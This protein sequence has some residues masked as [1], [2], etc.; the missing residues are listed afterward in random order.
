MSRLQDHILRDTRVNQPAASAVAVGSIYYV[1]DELVTERSNGSTWDDITDGGAGGGLIPS[2]V[3]ITPDTVANLPAAA[4]AGRV[5]LP[6][7]GYYLYRDN[8][9]SWDTWYNG[10][11]VTEPVDGD[12]AWINQGGASVSITNGG[13]YLSSP[14]SASTN[15]RIRKKAA[16]STPYTITAQVI[17]SYSVSHADMGV[18]FRQSSDGKLHTFRFSAA[19]GIAAT[20]VRSRKLTNETTVSSDYNLV[21]GAADIPIFIS[22]PFWMRI[23]DDGANRILSYSVDGYNFVTVLTIGRTDFLTAD[24]VGFF[25]NS[26]NASLACGITL[27]SWEEA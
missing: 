20:A 26:V 14:A 27:L 9:A 21:T 4:T 6:T 24:E 13:I 3:I 2:D 17:P 23:A 25:A 22:T 1:T 8:G 7:N 16:P 12:F 19:T 10:R 5:F 15:L 18:L 11:Q